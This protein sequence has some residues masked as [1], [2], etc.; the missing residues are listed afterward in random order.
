MRTS[1]SANV[2]RRPWTTKTGSRPPAHT[3]FIRSVF[4]IAALPKRSHLD[5]LITHVI[6]TPWRRGERRSP[7]NPKMRRTLRWGR[8]ERKTIG[9]GSI[10]G[11]DG[12]RSL[13]QQ[14]TVAPTHTNNYCND[15][16]D[17]SYGGPF[18]FGS[19]RLFLFDRHF[20]RPLGPGSPPQNSE[21][22]LGFS[23]SA[24]RGV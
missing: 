2:R 13:C 24:R 8:L 15:E 10:T 19:E 6:P 4:S 16:D 20:D 17:D 1:L 21:S 7:P 3:S 9:Q 18:V 5:P 11:G 23:G 14:S 22:I 12:R